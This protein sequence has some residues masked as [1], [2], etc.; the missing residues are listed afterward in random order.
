[1]VM[2][3]SAPIGAETIS[4]KLEKQFIDQSIEA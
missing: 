3:E 4:P 1:M 2:A